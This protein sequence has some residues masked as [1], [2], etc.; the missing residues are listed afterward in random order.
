[1]IQVLVSE[2][3]DFNALIFKYIGEAIRYF[4]CN[5]KQSFMTTTAWALREIEHA[6][7]LDAVSRLWSAM[8]NVFEDYRVI[9]LGYIT[10]C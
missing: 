10:F 2:S 7:V 9:S 5:T 8:P 1:M 3:N 6:D 4:A